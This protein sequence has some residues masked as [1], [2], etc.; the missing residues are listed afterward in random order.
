MPFF[1]YFPLF[2][3]IN[4]IGALSLIRYC[5]TPDPSNRATT[6]DILRHDW[7]AHGPVLSLRLRSST[8]PKT[9]PTTSSLSLNDP[10]T[11]KD[12][13]KV[14]LRTPTTINDKTASPTNSLVELELH[15]SSF[16]DTAKLRDKN[17]EQQRRNRVSAIP[18]STNYYTSKGNSTSARSTPRRPLS[19]T[20]DDSPL[21]T[22]FDYHY[23]STSEK[24]SQFSPP[25]SSI[26]TSS[27]PYSYRPRQTISPISNKSTSTSYATPDR[28]YSPPSAH[29]YTLA[30][31]PDAT[32]RTISPSNPSHYLVSYD[33]DSTLRDVKRKPIFKYTP[34]NLPTTSELNVVPSLSNSTTPVAPS[35]FTTSAVKFATPPTRRMSPFRD[36]ET[37][38]ISTARFLNHTISNP[39]SNLDDSINTATTNHKPRS[40]L[41]SYDLPSTTN[42]IRKS[43]LLDDN[44]NLISLKV[45][46]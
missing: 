36:P 4:I 26:T 30:R 38:S 22:P 14:R 43:R 28:I 40:Y 16:Y 1:I 25:S 13:E 34:P 17:K 31:S 42:N 20:L 32:Q 29:R 18:Q 46:D 23:T 39:S 3:L 21:T 9:P 8:T 45:H 24:P 19:L 37:H 6:K 5:L 41:T 7:L 15:T 12:Y 11:P 27:Q 10:S 35:V 44:N 33:F 2:N